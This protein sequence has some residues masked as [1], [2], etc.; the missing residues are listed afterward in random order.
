MV[1]VDM[2]VF[3]FFSYFR[4]R[5]FGIGVGVSRKVFRGVKKVFFGV[6]KL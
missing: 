6:G 1:K 3:S 5:G 2:N 4:L